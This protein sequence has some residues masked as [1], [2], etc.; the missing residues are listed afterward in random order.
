MEL[1]SFDGDDCLQPAESIAPAVLDGDAR[2]VHG[3]NGT[4]ILVGIAPCP[5]H[6]TARRESAPG[7]VESDS[8]L[9]TRPRST[10]PT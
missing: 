6:Q 8:T 5:D 4:A 7:K 2:T 3:K 1:R 10:M 9:A